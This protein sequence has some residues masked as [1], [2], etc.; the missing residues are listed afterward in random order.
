MDRQCGQAVWT[1]ST[2]HEVRTCSTGKQ[3]GQ[4]AWRH[5]HAAWR[6]GHVAW[7]HG[8]VAWTSSIKKGFPKLYTVRVD[9]LGHRK[10]DPLF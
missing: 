6:H 1:C 4:E 3:H 2:G 5:R 10:S 7:R 8:H 9:L